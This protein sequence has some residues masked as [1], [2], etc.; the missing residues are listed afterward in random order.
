M[1]DINN[2]D[3][4]WLYKNAAVALGGAA[5][6]GGLG[7]GLVAGGILLATGPIGWV[8]AAGAGIGVVVGLGVYNFFSWLFG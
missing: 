3:P 6:G 8:A 7:A 1:R 5:V 2:R 4:N